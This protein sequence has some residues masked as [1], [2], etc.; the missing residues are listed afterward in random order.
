MGLWSPY[1]TS[2]RSSQCSNLSIRNGTS[3]NKLYTWRLSAANTTPFS[4]TGEGRL[5]PMEDGSRACAEDK[6]LLPRLLSDTLVTVC[7]ALKLVDAGTVDP[8][9]WSGC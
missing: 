5:V 2:Q 4:H 9:A 7:E 6:K 8:R 3:G 1:P